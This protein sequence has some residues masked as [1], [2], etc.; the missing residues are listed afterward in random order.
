MDAF[1]QRLK[2][3]DAYPMVNEDFYKRT[4]SGGIVTLVVAVVMLL[5][6]ISE[7]RS[8]FYSATETKLVVDTSR[9]ESLRVNVS[10]F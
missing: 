6:F 4:L 7:T 10:T 2:R 9:G 1:L 3:L 8:Y 5:I